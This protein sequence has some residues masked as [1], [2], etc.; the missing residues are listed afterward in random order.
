MSNL[1]RVRLARTI[2]EGRTDVSAKNTVF[3]WYDSAALDAATFYAETF[4]DSAVGRVFHAPG[5]HPAGVQGDVLTVE[6]TV[7]GRKFVGL[8]GGPNFKPDEAISAFP[9]AFSS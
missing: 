2:D 1:S 3:L 8:N 9:N 6:F 7:L 5:D 4:P